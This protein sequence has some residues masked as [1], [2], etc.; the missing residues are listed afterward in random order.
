[1]NLYLLSIQKAPFII[2]TMLTHYKFQEN[3]TPE[4]II[5]GWWSV[6]HHTLLTR[7]RG[8]FGQCMNSSIIHDNICSLILKKSQPT[9]TIVT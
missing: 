1:M 8:G 6:I 2:V 9:F 3:F 7:K 4:P 5:Y